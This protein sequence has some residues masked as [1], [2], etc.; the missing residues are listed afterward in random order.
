MYRIQREVVRGID[1]GFDRE[2]YG[3]PPGRLDA[4]TR[5][6][7]TGELEDEAEVMTGDESILTVTYAVHYAVADAY[8]FRYR[9]DAPQEAVRA[10]AAAAVRATTA[11][12]STGE[13]LVGEREALERETQDRLE[14]VLRQV[15]AGL[16]ITAV[17]WQNVHAPSRV[18]PAFRDVASALE[19]K[20]RVIRE[21]EG[22]QAEVVA[23]ARGQAES[24]KLKAESQRVVKV[25]ASR[26]ESSAFLSRLSATRE[27]EALTRL[28]L[29][30]DTAERSLDQAHLILLLGDDVDVDMLDLGG[31]VLTSATGEAGSVG[32]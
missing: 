4:D 9:I 15:G 1:F 25:R 28:R 23:K 10:A 18:H 31:A 21:A 14:A 8:R 30:F 32:K 5:N 11:R 22:Y 19:D 20:E 13:V 12:R 26:G 29:L 24:I 17:T 2:P 27:S 6:D 16:R 7:P 3:T